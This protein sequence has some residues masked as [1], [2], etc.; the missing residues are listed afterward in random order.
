[1]ITGVKRD[2]ALLAKVKARAGDSITVLDIS[3][4]K[5]QLALSQ[6]LQQGV[7][8]HYFDHHQAGDILEHPL[9]QTYIN[10]SATTCSSL[11]VNDYLKGQFLAWA[12]VGAFGDNLPNIARLAASPL[13]LTETQ[14]NALQQLGDC[15]NYNAYGDSLDDLHF[16]PDELYAHCLPYRSPLDF[17][18][19]RHDIYQQLSNAYQQD[20]NLA[21]S[22][23]P[24]FVTERVAVYVLPNAT[25][26]R[27]VSG[28]FS[29]ELN[30]RYSARAHAVC[31]FNEAQQLKISVRAPLQQPSGADEL[32]ALFAT[33]GGRKAAAG[34]NQLAVHELGHFIQLFQQHYSA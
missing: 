17:I 4:A 32:C 8:V 3:L 26:S 9:L 30:Q 15:L 2:I 22:T 29:N 6:L 23:V 11:L 16:A 1:M 21:W 13:A 10:T 20:I 7:Q 31:T 12:I 5:N 18:A 27:R 34:I 14:L 33:G 24:E 25:W 28:V 19:D